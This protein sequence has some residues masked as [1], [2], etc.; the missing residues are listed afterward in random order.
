MGIGPGGV[1]PRLLKDCAV[2]LESL[3]L[4]FNRSIK[5]GKVPV[6]WKTSCLGPVPKLGR[7]ADLNDYRLVTLTSNVTKTLERLVL[8]FLRSEVTDAMDPLHFA[9]QEHIGVDNLIFCM[10]HRTYTYLEEPGCWVRIHF[11]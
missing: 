2:H 6:K 5:T 8:Q 9:N 11:L 4:I 7:P 3:Q 10:L 1:C